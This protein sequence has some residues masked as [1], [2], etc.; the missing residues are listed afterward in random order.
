MICSYSLFLF[1]CFVKLVPIFNN[2]Y[3]T[4]DHRTDGRVAGTG[5]CHHGTL[6]SQNTLFRCN[7]IGVA[8]DMSGG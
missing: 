5:Y 2:G 1:V 3:M 6:A 7:N 8:G 4:L